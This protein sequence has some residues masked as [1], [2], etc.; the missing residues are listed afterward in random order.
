MSDRA[1]QSVGGYYIPRIAKGQFISF[2]K[3]FRIFVRLNKISIVVKA[4]HDEVC[5]VLQKAIAGTLGKSFVLINIPPRFG[6]TKIMEALACYQLAY[7]PD[8]HMIYTSYSSGLATAS[9]RFIRET[10]GKEW[11]Q[12][13]FPSTQ[14]GSVQQADN[15]NTTGGGVVYGQG[16]GGTITGFGAGLKRRCG[17]FIVIDDPS[18]PDEAMSKVEQTSINFWLENTL[19]S[20]RNSP[21][22]PIIICMQRLSTDDLSGY[23]LKNYPNDVYQIKIAALRRGDMAMLYDGKEE[24]IIPETVNTESLLATERVNPF[25]FNAQYQQ[26][27]VILGGNLIKKDWFRYYPYMSDFKWQTKI[28][29]CDTALKAAQH[30]D[31]SVIQC[32]GKLNNCCYLIDQ[33]RGKWN[34]PMLLSTAAAFWAKHTSQTFPL[35]RF[36]IEEAAA[37]P[38][39]IDQLKV[40]GI[41]ATGIVRVKDKVARVKDVLA[42]PATGMVY[43]PT[44]APWLADLESELMGFREDGLSTQDDQ[45]DA[46][47]DGIKETLG[48]PP[49][50][51]NVLGPAP[52]RR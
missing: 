43:H 28:M 19:K 41:P 35:S 25:A 39:L 42:F 49:S 44:G 38:G 21:H 51:L 40:L 22:V 20:R 8:S 31:H 26:E 50:I 36:T 32:W 52:V 33:V 10:I 6:K 15:F 14:L 18:K 2:K 9:V 34:S 17:G 45:V 13:L 30:N 5:D 46:W 3:F 7:F 12:Q 47:A 37:G 1:V 48:G 16:T 29:T 23:V 24:S 11:Y 4:E 27:P